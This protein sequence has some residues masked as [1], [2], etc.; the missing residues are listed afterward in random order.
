MPAEMPAAKWVGGKARVRGASRPSG[1]AG[2]PR[3]STSQT[4][5]TQREPTQGAEGVG[6]R[7]VPGVGLSTAPGTMWATGPEGSEPTENTRN[8]KETR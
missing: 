3:I 7:M 4:V 6:A 2:W 1:A 5:K 8:N